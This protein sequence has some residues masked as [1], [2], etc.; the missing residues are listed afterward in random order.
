[1]SNGLILADRRID[2][3][4]AQSP[5]A[6]VT[7]LAHEYELTADKHLFVLALIAKLVATRAVVQA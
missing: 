2:Q 4:L 3:L 7:S 1:M 6:A 5:V